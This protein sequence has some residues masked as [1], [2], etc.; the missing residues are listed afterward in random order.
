MDGKAEVGVVLMARLILEEGKLDTVRAML[1]TPPDRQ[2]LSAL[3]ACSLP[4]CT[5]AFRNGLGPGNPS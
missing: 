2:G 1:L 4:Q 3:T 5:V